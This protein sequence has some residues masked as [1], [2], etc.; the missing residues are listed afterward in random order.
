MFL[1]FTQDVHAMIVN[2]VYRYAKYLPLP[3]ILTFLQ[4]SNLQCYKL[5]MKIENQLCQ[6]YEVSM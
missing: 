1:F 5:R 4:K 2:V 6:L 3:L